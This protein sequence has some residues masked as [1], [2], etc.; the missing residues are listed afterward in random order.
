MARNLKLDPYARKAATTLAKRNAA[1]VAD[2]Y[3]GRNGEDVPA[4]PDA[5]REQWVKDVLTV[6]SYIG[7]AE[8]YSG[9]YKADDAFTAFA[10]LIQ[11][12]AFKLRK[13]IKGEK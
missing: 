8:G 6:G 5:A 2:K 11:L 10:R 7:W 9:G 13:I 3:V 4:T 1:R 12:P